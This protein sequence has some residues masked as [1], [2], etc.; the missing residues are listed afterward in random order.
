MLPF[1][2][3]VWL[4]L[5]IYF[6]RVSRTCYSARDIVHMCEDNQWILNQTPDPLEVECA[7]TIVMFKDNSNTYY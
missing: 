3:T 5:L 4:G 1:H 7:E 2:F 6:V